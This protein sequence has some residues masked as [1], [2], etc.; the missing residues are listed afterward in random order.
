MTNKIFV[1]LDSGQLRLETKERLQEFRVSVHCH[2]VEFSA[3]VVELRE[4][5]D[6]HEGACYITAEETMQIS[7]L[8]RV[9]AIKAL[10]GDVP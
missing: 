1:S 10:E 5:G 2:S 3:S 7:Q 4:K 8:L 9:A 6:I